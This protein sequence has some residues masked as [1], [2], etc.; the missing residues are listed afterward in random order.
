MSL[1]V[2]V[3]I[4]VCMHTQAYEFVYVEQSSLGEQPTQS[5]LRSCVS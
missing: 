1:S 2:H 3:C 4:H 5:A